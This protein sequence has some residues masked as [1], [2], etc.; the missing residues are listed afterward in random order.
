MDIPLIFCIVA[1]YIGCMFCAWVFTG[2]KEPTK[3]L[4]LRLCFW[5]IELVT[6]LPIVIVRWFINLPLK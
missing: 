5:P 4:I 1:L 2:Q 3:L 6:T